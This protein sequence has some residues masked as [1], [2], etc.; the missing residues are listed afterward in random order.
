MEGNKA[1]ESSEEAAMSLDLNPIGPV[2]RSYNGCWEKV[3]KER[4]GA[5]CKRRVVQNSSVGALLGPWF[6]SV[7]RMA[8]RLPSSLFP[9]DRCP[10]SEPSM[11]PAIAAECY[12]ISQGLVINRA[13]SFGTDQK[14]D[15]DVKKGVLLNALKLLNIRASDKKKNLAKQKAEAQK[16]LYGQGSM[17][18]LSPGS[19]D[20]E[21]QRHTL[22][23]RKEELKERLA[24]VR[25]QISKEEYENR[26]LGN[27][28]R[29]YPPEDKLLLEKYEG[30]LSTAFQTF[31][32]GRAASLQRE[33]NNPLKRMKVREMQAPLD[34][35][36]VAGGLHTARADLQHSSKATQTSRVAI[37]SAV[38]KE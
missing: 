29:I 11:I 14:I 6:S 10:E 8:Q 27:Y 22:E 20:W 12:Y 2:E 5:V 25:K 21:K 37:S 17:K 38:P 35:N 19:S 36:I 24:Q 23:R 3:R 28:R 13:P 1:L 4:P 7:N 30:L 15:H 26:H 18:R 32:A 34:G 33:M 16:R 31:L 9:I